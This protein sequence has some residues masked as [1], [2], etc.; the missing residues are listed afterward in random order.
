MESGADVMLMEVRVGRMLHDLMR[1][2][3]EVSVVP[4]GRTGR[5]VG[6]ELLNLKKSEKY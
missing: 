6:R 2:E 5:R 1:K 4:T 3:T